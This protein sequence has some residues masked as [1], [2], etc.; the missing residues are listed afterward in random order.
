ARHGTA[1][2]EPSGGLRSP[3]VSAALTSG[4]ESPW[5]RFRANVWSPVVLKA[6]GA[7]LGLSCLALAGAASMRHAPAGTQVTAQG[8][9]WVAGEEPQVKGDVAGSGARPPLPGSSVSPARKSGPA[10]AP[11]ASAGAREEETANR[12]L[13]CAEGAAKKEKKGRGIAGDGR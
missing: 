7:C 6:G 4:G 5:R 9:E 11:G 8:T 1:S 2:H 10:P 13:P 3:A 12:A